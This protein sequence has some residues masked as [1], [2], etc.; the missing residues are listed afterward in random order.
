MTI[1]IITLMG[2]SLK[3]VK[4]QPRQVE[5]RFRGVQAGGSVSSYGEE[6]LIGSV[7]RHAEDT[8]Q[9]DGAN[10]A[11]YLLLHLHARKSQYQEAEQRQKKY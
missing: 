4:L 5:Y 8:S 9:Y 3:V 10:D 2:V 11:G 7:H 1:S 6:I